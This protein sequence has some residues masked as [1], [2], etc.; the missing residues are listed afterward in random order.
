MTSIEFRP[1]GV[2]ASPHFST[3]RSSHRSSGAGVLAAGVPEK[4]LLFI[5]L[6]DGRILC[7]ETDSSAT[8]PRGKDSPHRVLEGHRGEVRSMIF[9]RGLCKGV[10]FTGAAD[11]CIKMW[12]LSDPR[13]GTPCVNSLHG[14]G[15]TVL[16]LEYGADM[17]LSSSTDG[18][19][20]MWRDQSPTKL[21]R[22]PAYSIRQKISPES[23]GS[24]AGARQPKETWFLSLSIREGEAPSIFAGDSGGF[25]HIYKPDSSSGDGLENQLFVL[26]WKKQ[27]HDLGISRILTVPMESFLIT[28]AYDQKFKTLDSLSG[29][30]IFEESNQNCVCFNGMAWDPVNQDVILVDDKGNIGFYNVYTE[31]CLVWRN[32]TQDP[33]VQVHYQ[34][35]A[36]RLLV[37]SPHL[38]RVFDVVRAVKFSELN[39][40]VGPVVGIASRN[41][42]QGGLLYTAAMDNT[43]RMWDADSLDSVKCLK[44]K[45]HEITAMVYLPR[46]NVIVTGHENS[47]LKM[48]SMDCQVDACLRTVTGKSAHS[49]TISCLA[50]ASLAAGNDYVFDDEASDT[51]DAGGEKSVP[52]SSEILIAG[53]YDRHVSFWKVT[54]TSDGT[55]MAKFDRVFLAHNE[56]D[57]EVLAVGYS[58][59]ANSVFTGGNAG[60][61]RKWALQGSRRPEA[62][63]NGHDDA[64]TCFAVDGN[65]LFSGSTD[66]SVLIWETS[67]GYQLKRVQMH[68]ASI[69]ALLVVPHSGVVVSCA[70]DGRVVLWDPQVGRP[71]VAEVAV[72]EQPEEFRSMHYAELTRTI[73]VGCESGK[74]ITF[75]VPSS[76]EGNGPTSGA[77][78]GTGAARRRSSTTV[79]R[80]AAEPKALSGVDTPPSEADEDRTTLEA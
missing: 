54:L 67:Q 75:P 63:Y 74:V 77:A 66:R 17:L 14:H 23:R 27:V 59:V 56:P 30:V 50:C 43:I 46:A 49:N 69:Q 2:F 38:L 52:T 68:N 48:W 20:A 58:P 28:C 78:A 26:A 6:T 62:E 36:R 24:Q 15:G 57:D 25:V 18:I 64:V 7:W 3:Q 19:L 47:D 45:K 1:A 41:T 5:G 22:F 70:F 40:H 21:L 55:A 16:A 29:Q 4:G 65:F 79:E 32:V 76:G 60:V 42:P 72:Y 11:R 13:G 61:I 9:V 71:D 80:F 33:I 37:L 51:Y 39:E 12:D 31:S 10:M 35:S 73:F 8:A 53:S 44:E 34:P